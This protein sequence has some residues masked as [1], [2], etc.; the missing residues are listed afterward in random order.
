MI[1]TATLLPRA[2]NDNHRDDASDARARF[3]AAIEGIAAN[4]ATMRRNNDAMEAMRK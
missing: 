4:T 3:W 1:T 2:A